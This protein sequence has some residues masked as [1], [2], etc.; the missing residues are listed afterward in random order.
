MRLKVT[1]SVHPGVSLA[2]KQAFNFSDL[3][4]LSRDQ[5]VCAL[6][7]GDQQETEVLVGCVNGAVKTFSTEKGKFIETRQCGDASQ[8]RFTGLAVYDGYGTRS[9]LGLYS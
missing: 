6:T 2:K 1:V 3:S 4:T 7:W 9:V 5:E 8:G